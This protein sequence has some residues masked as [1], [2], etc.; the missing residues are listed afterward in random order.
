[1]SLCCER[2]FSARFKADRDVLEGA[3]LA[4]VLL[5]G[6]SAN[7]GWLQHLLRR[8]FA[9]YIAGI[10]FVQ[11]PELSASRGSGTCRCFSDLQLTLN[12]GADKCSA[13]QRSGTLG[14]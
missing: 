8:D 3:P 4:V 1:M 10:P 7:F 5:S 11:I 12:D 13:E 2:F 6:G 14:T 9:E